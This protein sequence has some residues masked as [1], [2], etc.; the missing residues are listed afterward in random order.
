MQTSNLIEVNGL[1]AGIKVPATVWGLEAQ[2]A[3]NGS[4][5]YTRSAV[6]VANGDRLNVRQPAAGTANTIRD[7]ILVVGGMAAAETPHTLLEAPVV[8]TFSSTTAAG[9]IGVLDFVSTAVSV[10]EAASTVTLQVARTGGSSGAVTVAYS[11][12]SGTAVAGSDFTS[13]SGTLSWANGEAGTKPITVSILNDAVNEPAESFTVTLS[14]PTGGATLGAA[15][16]AT[17]NINDDDPATGGG[18]GSSSS[19]G[20][21]GSIDAWSLTML[22]ALVMGGFVRGRR[23]F[24]R[25]SWP[26]DGA[27]VVSRRLLSPQRTVA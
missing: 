6:W 17:V 4:T 27:L 18:G 8:D 11:T 16:V 25:T 12:A 2:L 15:A 10:T 13:A 19:G 5:T 21:G 1:G 23:A 26:S 22:L 3:L 20:G 24:R 9:S 7:A 14:S